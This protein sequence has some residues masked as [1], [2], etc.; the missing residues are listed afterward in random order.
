M[1]KTFKKYSLKNAKQFWKII[2]YSVT[3]KQHDID[4]IESVQMRATNM[5]PGFKEK[6]L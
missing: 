4:K 1:V 5:L 6:K 3:H 2:E